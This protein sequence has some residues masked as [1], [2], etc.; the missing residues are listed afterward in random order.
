M[1]KIP[2]IIWT[3]GKKRISFHFI[4]QEIVIEKTELQELSE[5]KGKKKGIEMDGYIFY[6]N[7]FF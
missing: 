6:L 7:I 4:S 3:V 5:S 2:E 1:I